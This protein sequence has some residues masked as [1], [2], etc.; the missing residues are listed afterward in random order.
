MKQSRIWMNPNPSHPVPRRF[1]SSS[2]LQPL[3]HLASS[4]RAPRFHQTNHL[5]G[6]FLRI[7]STSVPAPLFS[8]ENTTSIIPASSLPNVQAY[9]LPLFRDPISQ[10]KAKLRNLLKRPQDDLHLPAI[11][12]MRTSN[13]LPDYSQ[14][15][16][17]FPRI[18]IPSGFAPILITYQLK[19]SASAESSYPSS[20]S[21]PTLLYPSTKTHAS[22]PCYQPISKHSILCFVRI[23]IRNISRISS[24]RQHNQMIQTSSI[25]LSFTR[26]FRVHPHPNRF[27]CFGI[28]F[29]RIHLPIRGFDALPDSSHTHPVQQLR[30]KPF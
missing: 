4:S 30:Q 5:P 18:Q 16:K 6:N 25:I 28:N 20:T 29:S 13:L 24:Q 9:P 26:F 10:D 3:S 11:F 17:P 7:P 27:P 8:T 1:S 12:R 22:V 15:P 2:Q 21:F 23:K 19:S 14:R